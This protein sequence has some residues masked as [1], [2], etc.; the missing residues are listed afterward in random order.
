[1]A[2][3]GDPLAIEFVRG[4]VRADA[5][6]W[7]PLDAVAFGLSLRAVRA[8]PALNF[9]TEASFETHFAK[10]GAEFGFKTAGEYLKGA[11]KLIGSVGEKGVQSFTRANG[12]TVIYRAAT[13]E[14]A[15]VTRDN[16]IRKFFKPKGGVEYYVRQ[17]F[18]AVEEKLAK[19]Q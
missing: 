8:A 12:D 18:T 10:H 19:V 5:L 7:G 14:F 3:L 13:N 1:M 2:D 11:V 6:G 16:V 15:V 17:L 4:N 9:A